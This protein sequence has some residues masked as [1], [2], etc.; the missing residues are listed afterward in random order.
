M[1]VELDTIDFKDK[2]FQ[3][4]LKKHNI[5]TVLVDECSEAGGWPTYR[6]RGNKKNLTKMINKY[7]QD[8]GLVELITKP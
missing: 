7:W 6:Y 8:E 2:R 5:T 4:F 3:T 1:R